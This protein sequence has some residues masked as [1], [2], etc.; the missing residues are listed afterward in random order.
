M[1]SS[2]SRHRGALWVLAGIAIVA[3]LH[4]GAATLVV[5]PAGS[6]PYTTIQAA[7]DAAV[8]GQDDVL[9]LCGTYRENLLLKDRVSVRGAGAACTTIDGRRLGSVVRIPELQDTIELSGFTVRNGAPTSGNLGS[10]IEMRSSGAPLITRNIV[11]G[12]FASGIAAY[13]WYST[14]NLAPVITQNV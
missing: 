5:D 4:A 3:V 2:G 1:R 13:T 12:N 10:G 11:E 8:P 14:V 9:V 6:T 7:I